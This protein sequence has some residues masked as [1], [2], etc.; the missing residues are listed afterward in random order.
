MTYPFA[1]RIAVEPGPRY[2]IYF[3]PAPDSKLYR[4]GSSILGYDCYTG[5]AVDFPQEF[6][7]DAVNWNELTAAL[8]FSRHI[9]GAVSSL[10]ILHRAATRQR[11]AELCR[12]RPCD[13]HVCADGA[14]G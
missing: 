5:A 13:P 7:N 9:E 11:V 2:A 1:S 8:R 14:A 3:I 12:P 10:A 6:G 4:Y